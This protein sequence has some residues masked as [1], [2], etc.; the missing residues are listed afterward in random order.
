MKLNKKNY[1]N[2]HSRWSASICK[3]FNECP[4][5]AIAMLNGEWEQP[6]TDALMVGSFVDAW[7][8]GTIENF[9]LTNPEIFNSRTG[10]LKAQFRN[11]MQMIE[12]CQQ[13][14]VFMSY[15]T[16]QKQKILTGELFGLP[17]KAKLDFYKKG[18]RIVDL[19]TTADFQPKYAP[20]QGRV[21]FIQYWQWPMQMAIYQALEGNKLPCF[22][23]I[24]SKQDPPNIE[25]V[26]IPQETLDAEMEILGSKIQAWDAM[27]RGIIEPA[28]C[29]E[30][31][32][33]RATKK[34]TTY[35]DLDELEIEA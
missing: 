22:L 1:Y 2:D 17:F 24:V 3:V 18:Q 8:E 15:C 30:C 11:A 7:F 10:E 32:Y 26:H 4:A 14:E 34:L 21:S 33:C 12:R 5:R 35:I 28:R 25:V 19:K 13:D 16:G 31:E 9:K 27:R 23:A 20:G 6:K 29:G